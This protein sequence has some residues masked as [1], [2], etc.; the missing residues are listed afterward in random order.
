MIFSSVITPDNWHLNAPQY[1]KG[2]EWWPGVNNHDFQFGCQCVR[3][4]LNAACGTA[5]LL[6]THTHTH[7]EV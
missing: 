5:T 2:I 1:M 3:R 7:T 6:H 4:M